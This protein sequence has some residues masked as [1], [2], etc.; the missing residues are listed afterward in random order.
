VFWS[1]LLLTLF[2]VFRKKYEFLLS[3]TLGL[4]GYTLFLV[5]AYLYFFADYERQ[6]LVSYE[7]YLGVFFLA[8][9]LLGL[10]LIIEQQLYRKKLIGFT[11]LALV[12]T[13]RPTPSIFI[14]LSVRRDAAV[15]RKD[16]TPISDM[17][18]ASTPAT[19]KVW[20]IWQKSTGIEAMVLR[21]EI[22]P[23]KMNP[24]Q[25]SLGEPYYEGDI[26]TTNLSVEEFEKSLRS[27]DFLAIGQ[28]DDQFLRKYG[29]LFTAPPQSGSLY[30]IQAVEGSP[31]RLVAL[32]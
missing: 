31:L 20:F 11:L 10:K 13:F 6:I 28:L 18:S 8:Y 23:R 32:P 7:R 15:F 9:S 29:S 5:M 14:P 25:T 4:I 26:W 27:Y 1:G 21:Y 2:F 24:G 12:L 30:Q 17:V 22:I 3:Y 19:A 16:L